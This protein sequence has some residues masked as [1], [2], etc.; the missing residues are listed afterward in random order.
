MKKV[1]YV[2]IAVCMGLTACSKEGGF[3]PRH[4]IA[5]IYESYSYHSEIWNDELYS[6]EYS[7]ETTPKHLSEQ[8][9][10]NGKILSSIQIYDEEGSPWYTENFEYENKRISKVT[11]SSQSDW[12][13]MS[14][15]K[16]NY[17]KN[18]LVSANLY[19]GNEVYIG[20]DFVHNNK[21]KISEVR[22][23]YFED[24]YKKNVSPWQMSV[25]RL[26]LP[27]ENYQLLKRTANSL[28]N[29]TTTKGV[30]IYTQKY[31][32]DGDN[33]KRVT[34]DDGWQVE[35]EYD[36]MSNP[37]Y[38][39]LDSHLFGDGM[40]YDYIISKNNVVKEQYET[41]NRE[42]TYRYDKKLPIVKICVDK[43]ET[44]S[45]YRYTDTHTVYYEYE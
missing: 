1:I 12:G 10:W 40:L 22:W 43:N 31:V 45:H 30:D 11:Y 17:D 36:N 14:Y 4:K 33:V 13:L 38:G 7:D 25:L 39:L 35:Y 8:W 37:L 19:N 18:G 41:W 32:W 29:H 9:I 5:K 24:S 28:P 20:V 21:G 34:D 16:F 42:Y 26:I 6:W 23:T 27:S 3:A 44:D 2:L 15:W